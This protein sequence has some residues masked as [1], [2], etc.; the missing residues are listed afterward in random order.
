MHELWV[1]FRRRRQRS[2]SSSSAQAAAP[3][4][5]APPAGSPLGTSFNP[6]LVTVGFVSDL[7]HPHQLR[8]FLCRFA[9]D[10]YGCRQPGVRC[11]HK[12]TELT[13]P[14]DASGE[15]SEA[16]LATASRVVG[17]A[18]PV[19][20][21]EG[22][23]GDGSAIA[24]PV[25]APASHERLEA[26]R[27][28]MR[29]VLEANGGSIA[30]A[31][32]PA[33]FGERFPVLGK[34]RPADYGFK[35]LLQLLD[36]IPDVCAYTRGGAGDGVTVTLVGGSGGGGGVSGTA[37]A[38]AVPP[39]GAAAAVVPDDGPV[40]L[41]LMQARVMR[42]LGA[43]AQGA[44]LRDVHVANIKPEYQLRYGEFDVKDAGF[45]TMSKL[46]THLQ[47]LGLCV[48]T[49]HPGGHY[50]ARLTA[51]SFLCG[52]PDDAPIEMAAATPRRGGGGGGH[53]SAGAELAEAS[54]HS[55]VQPLVIAVRV[56]SEDAPVAAVRRAV[57]PI[58]TPTPG[59]YACVCVFVRVCVCAGVRADVC[60]LNV[61]RHARLG[62]HYIRGTR[63][64]MEED[65]THEF[66]D[67]RVFC[68]CCTCCFWGAYVC[69]RVCARALRQRCCDFAVAWLV[70]ASS[71]K[72]SLSYM[73]KIASKYI[74]SFLNNRGGTLFFGVADDGTV[75]G[76]ALNRYVLARAC[77]RDRRC[78][79]CTPRMQGGARLSAAPV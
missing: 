63:I 32:L 35:K 31:V 54:A 13:L 75:N 36:A 30:G 65:E 28:A 40:T 53:G 58:R 50:T 11:V 12:Y 25:P 42:I 22:G 78:D 39:G 47:A 68:G 19:R 59:A 64:R 14:H 3:G 8:A 10:G 6:D 27:G 49:K 16:A 45:S 73:G 69:V 60:A 52:E 5:A 71:A 51:R 44:L 77:L 26:L 67:V 2:S 55:S 57:S 66:K 9:T 37:V 1:R 15:L 20:G 74:T 4:A 46:F 41:P 70:K 48:L 24:S 79:L 17:S 76:I 62:A 23:E 34:L 56:P 29:A 43:L 61:R 18:A 21:T 7:K 33:R 72:N 38:P